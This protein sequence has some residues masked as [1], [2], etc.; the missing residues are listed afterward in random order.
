MPE[1]SVGGKYRAEFFPIALAAPV[2]AGIIFKL[3]ALPRLELIPF[4]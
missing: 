4:L 3:A 2:L 1:G